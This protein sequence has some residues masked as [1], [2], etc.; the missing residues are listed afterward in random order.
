MIYTSG[1][2]LCISVQR[3]SAFFFFFFFLASHPGVAEST[4]DERERETITGPWRKKKG[5]GEEP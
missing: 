4:D 2:V 1:R 3:A 5:M